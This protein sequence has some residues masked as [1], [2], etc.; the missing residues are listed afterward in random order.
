MSFFWGSAAEATDRSMKEWKALWDAEEAEKKKSEIAE[1]QLAMQQAQLDWEKQRVDIMNNY[2]TG[3]L[4][5]AEREAWAKETLRLMGETDNPEQQWGYYTALRDAGSMYASTALHSINNSLVSSPREAQ[6]FLASVI[7]AQPGTAFDPEWVRINADAM[8]GYLRLEGK[9]REQYVQGYLDLATQL[10]DEKGEVDQLLLDRLRLDN[11]KLSSDIELNEA[12]TSNLNQRT[13]EIATRLGWDAEKHPYELGILESQ[14]SLLQSEAAIKAL[15]ADN[16]P[17]QILLQNR[18][19]YASI[20]G[21][22]DANRLFAETFDYQVRQMAAATGMQEEELRHLLATATVRDA[23]VTGNLDQ[24]NATVDYIKAQTETEGYQQQLLGA[25]TDASRIANQSA[26]IGIVNELVEAGQGALLA[27]V[28]PG[29]L[30]GMVGE[31]QLPELVTALEGIANERLDSDLKLRAANARIAIAQADFD[32]QTMADRAQQEANQARAS[33]VQ[34]DLLQKQ[35]DYYDDDREFSQW[36]TRE[37]LSI[38][39]M[40]AQAYVNNLNRPAEVKGEA[41]LTRMDVLKT[42]KDATGW[43]T[44]S[45][46]GERD[47]L[48]DMQ[49]ELA[50]LQVALDNNNLPVIQ[51]LANKYGLDPSTGDSMAAALEARIATK[52]DNII[53]GLHQIIDGGLAYNMEFV[54]SDL[55]LPDDDPLFRAALER[56]P[57][58][59]DRQLVND[60]VAPEVQDAAN[61]A[62]RSAIG[63]SPDMADGTGMLGGSFGVYSYLMDTVGEDALKAAGINGAY[64]LLGTYQQTAASYQENVQRASAF[65]SRYSL[66]PSVRADRDVMQKAITAEMQMVDNAERQIT[67]LYS[68]PGGFDKQTR[69]T[70]QLQNLASYYG[71]DVSGLLTPVGTIAGL[72]KLREF[73]QQIRSELVNT[74]ASIQFLNTF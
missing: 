3:V 59:R 42:V 40:Q 25:Q 32:E 46:A 7:N 12:N 17:T 21:Q 51:D 27:Q 61:A 53:N 48:N 10:G 74:Q 34:A 28:A 57:F 64:D 4:D 45:L 15:Q 11:N 52:Q 36:A 35:L 24:L 6:Q 63:N 29:L 43:T 33:G 5:R 69:A 73:F 38:Q 72:P 67:T 62:I 16:M 19:L 60:A 22:E 47:Q 18:Q 70:Q 54:P 13:Q 26:R 49:L 14:T 68:S 44:S 55:G 56:Y 8:A 1:K 71:L 37:G 23:I 50:R 58:F 30:S 2:N 31:E 39:R 41:P 66:D 9:E 65:A 20:Q